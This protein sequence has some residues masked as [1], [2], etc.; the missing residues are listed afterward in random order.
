MGFCSIQLT[1]VETVQVIIGH[2]PSVSQASWNRFILSHACQERASPTLWA[3]QTFSSSAALG[4]IGASL[5]I[6]LSDFF[7]GIQMISNRPISWYVG[8]F[9]QDGSIFRISR[10]REVERPSLQLF[11]YLPLKTLCVICLF[12]S[13]LGGELQISI[14][15]PRQAFPPLGSL[16]YPFGN[17]S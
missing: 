12:L 1:Q 11:T 5:G 4:A 7:V 9:L 10:I 15:W 16:P 6:E 17:R 2:L 13:C 14:Q 8:V 3:F